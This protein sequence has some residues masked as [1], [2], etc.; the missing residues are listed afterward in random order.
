[1]FCSETISSYPIVTLLNTILSATAIGVSDR[2]DHSETGMAVSSVR[3]FLYKLLSVSQ[4]SFSK[5]L[6]RHTITINNLSDDSL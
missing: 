5:R 4:L 6:A 3:G 1:M 2:A